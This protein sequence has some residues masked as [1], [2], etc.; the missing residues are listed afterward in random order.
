MAGQTASIGMC[1]PRELPAGF[2]GEFARTAEANGLDD[3]WFIEDC[4]FTAAIPLLTTA[5]AVTEQLRAGFAILPAVTRNPSLIAMELA[6]IADI[7]PG[8]LFAGIGHGV[9]S[10]MEQIGALPTSQLGAYEEIVTSVRRLLRGETVNHTGAHVS[11]T[12]VRLETPPARVPPVLAGV[13]RPKSV[14]MAGRIADGVILAEGTGPSTVRRVLSEAA[15]SHPDFHC[16]VFTPLCVIPDRMTAR[17]VMAPMVQGMV[18][19]GSY[20]LSQQ[21]FW[22]DLQAACASGVEAMVLLPDE[23][24]TELGAVG[25]MD[26][27]IENVRALIDAGATHVSFFPGPAVDLVRNDLV[28]AGQIA[29]VVRGQ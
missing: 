1:Y 15:T 22:S 7:A 24:W 11:L 20:P 16:V 29:T 18:A 19:R 28:T 10:W 26:D 23:V 27:A 12:D 21:P 8:R 13:E 17:R 4:F 2:V 9:R 3:V 25:T 14:A 6:T 5:L